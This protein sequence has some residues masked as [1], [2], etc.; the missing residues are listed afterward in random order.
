MPTKRLFFCITS[1]F[2]VFLVS[3][4]T[5]NVQTSDGQSDKTFFEASGFMLSQNSFNTGADTLRTQA[6]RQIGKT[7]ATAIVPLIFDNTGNLVTAVEYNKAK[8]LDEE[9]QFETYF[10]DFKNYKKV[11][12]KLVKNGRQKQEFLNTIREDFVHSLP[13]GTG[14]SDSIYGFDPYETYH[15]TTEE[16]KELYAKQPIAAKQSSL[17]TQAFSSTP[18]VWVADIVVREP[19]WSTWANTGHS[20]VV[21]K[22]NCSGLR[23]SGNPNHPNT[24]AMEAI[25]GVGGPTPDPSD[26][27]GEYPLLDRFDPAQHVDPIKL[28]YVSGLT[29]TQIINIRNFSLAQD[30]GTYDI[31]TAPWNTPCSSSNSNCTWYCSLLVWRAYKDY[32]GLNLDPGG[33]YWVWPYDLIASPHTQTYYSE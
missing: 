28:A 22:L 17:K 32:T 10:T 21:T 23:C 2:I 6:G 12:N 1:L 3:C 31:F 25:K 26:D 11:V 30:P 14:A 16:V 19:N 5:Q 4:S 33:G 13:T 29:D 7:R 27:L 8:D 9:A 20:G 24:R 18:S 15:L